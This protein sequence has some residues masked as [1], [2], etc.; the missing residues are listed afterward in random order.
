MA[1][2]VGSKVAGGG[3]EADARTLRIGGYILDCLRQ[4]EPIAPLRLG[5]EPIAACRKYDANVEAGT[6]A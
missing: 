4:Q 5:S 2:V 1:G 6:L 3:S